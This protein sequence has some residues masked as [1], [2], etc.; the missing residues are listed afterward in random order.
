MNN[1]IG[2]LQIFL[3]NLGKNSCRG[4]DQAKVWQALV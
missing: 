4:P 3:P 2:Q 1:L